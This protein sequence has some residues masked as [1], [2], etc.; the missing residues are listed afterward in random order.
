MEKDELGAYL[1]THYPIA[2]HRLNLPH[3]KMDIAIVNEPDDLLEKLSREDAEG[4]LILPYWSYLWP[5]SIGLAEHLSALDGLDD[6]AALEMGCGL[7]VAG[8]AAC[9]LGARLLFIDYE[10]DALLFSA[11]NALQNGIAACA[12]F[13]QMDWNYPCLNRQFPLIL[14]AD[15]IFEE[16]NWHPILIFLRRYLTATGEAI[17][18]EPNRTNTPAF[19]NLATQYGFTYESSSVTVSHENSAVPVAIYHMRRGSKAL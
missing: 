5:A 15:V 18:S 4:R 19:L 14:G 12:A 10:R 2:E 11:Y 8:I 7:G 9:Q 1:A 16:M 17:F 6:Q 3:G 13:L